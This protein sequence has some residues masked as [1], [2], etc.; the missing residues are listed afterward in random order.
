MRSS[1]WSNALSILSATAALGCLAKPPTH[2]ASAIQAAP[3]SLSIGRPRPALATETSYE[4]SLPLLREPEN[5]NAA[6]GPNGLLAIVKPDPRHHPRIYVVSQ[7]TP[8][9]LRL[10]IDRYGT[11]PRWAPIGRRVACTVW[12]SRARPWDLCIVGLDE[13]DTLYP[14]LNANAVR[15]RWSPDA[16]YL[17]VSGT[18]EGGAASVLYLV[19][20][21][22]GQSRA[23]DTLQVYSEYEMAW[24]PDSH[25]LAVS[26]PI[27][28]APSE[29]V[30]EAEIWVYDIA[31]QRA[32]VNTSGG[33]PNRDP[34]WIDN[35][36]LMFTKEERDS[37]SR[38]ES[39][40]VDVTPSER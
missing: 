4:D 37:E 5:S 32:R 2:R 16:R 3:A 26:R 23:L 39:L 7:S 31:G 34:R 17:A 12:K 10:L 24:S 14:L 6:P 19:D 21:H 13:P 9:S 38:S 35:T 20:T 27:R 33:R 29:D 25:L 1:R 36:R 40:V 30:N 18:L 22:S 8:D 28:L 11:K 15:Y